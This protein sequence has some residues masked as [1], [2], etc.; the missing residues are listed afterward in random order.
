M[1]DIFGPPMA[2]Q[3]RKDSLGPDTWTWCETRVKEIK[4]GEFRLYQD[5][6]N[7]FIELNKDRQQADSVAVEKWFGQYCS[8]KV[9][10]IPLEKLDLNLFS[11]TLM[12]SF[13]DNVHIPILRSKDGTYLSGHH[14]FTS[15]E[16]DQAL[17]ELENIPKRLVQ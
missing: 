2:S 14:T 15:R 5:G 9:I 3:L 1:N 11:P 12:V 4:M 16:F 7:W 13:I 6:I 10:P 8:V 17:H